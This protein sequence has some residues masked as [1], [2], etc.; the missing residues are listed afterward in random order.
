MHVVARA[1]VSREEEREGKSRI[2][3]ASAKY[4]VDQSLGLKTTDA[5]CYFLPASL[6]LSLSFGF[7]CARIINDLA[8]NYDHKGRT[9]C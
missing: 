8:G 3:G 7:P 4:D 1:R 9:C 2:R 6:F 5:T